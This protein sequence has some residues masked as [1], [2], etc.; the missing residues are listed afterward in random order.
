MYTVPCREC[1]NPVQVKK[2]N[3]RALCDICRPRVRRERKRRDAAMY[4]KM[5]QDASEGAPC[6]TLK[7]PFGLTVVHDPLP[8]GGFSPGISFPRADLKLMIAGC[9]FTNGTVFSDGHGRRY[10]YENG[11]VALCEEANDER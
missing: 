7:L 8:L 2:P 10:R 3:P 11:G 6:R 4:R 5:E 1:R 9:A